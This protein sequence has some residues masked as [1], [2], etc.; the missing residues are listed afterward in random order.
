MSGFKFQLDGEGK[1]EFVDPIEPWVTIIEDDLEVLDFDSLESDLE[2]V[3]EN[4]RSKALD[5][6]KESYFLWHQEQLICKAVIED[7]Q[8]DKTSGPWVLYLIKRV[9]QEQMQKEFYVGVSKTKAFR[10]KA[11]AQM[12]GTCWFGWSFMRGPIPCCLADD[13]E[14]LSN[15]NFTFITD[16]QKGMLLI[17]AKLFPVVEHR[18]KVEPEFPHIEATYTLAKVGVDPFLTDLT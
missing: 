15:F 11:K 8:E 4:A 3:P 5:F 7:A 13:L 16:R 6:K 17:I 9:V 1:V 18:T 12:E 10:A 2:N 14:L